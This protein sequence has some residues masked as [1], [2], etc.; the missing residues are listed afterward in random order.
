MREVAQQAGVAISSVSRVL[1]GHPDVSSAMRDK[2]M[3]VVEALGY[4]PDMLAQ[5]LRRQ[6][7]TS[8]GFAASNISNPVLTDAVRGAEGELRRAGFSL[9][10]T[11]ADGDP[12]LDAANIDLLQRRRVDA[13][14][15]AHGDE[16][17]ASVRTAIQEADVPLVLIDRDPPR[18]SDIPIVKFDHRKGMREAAEHLRDLGHKDIALLIGGPRRPARERKAGVLDVYREGSGL[19]CEVLE[20]DFSI[21]FGYAATR[22]ILTQA[23]RPTALIAGGN[24]IMHGSLRALR[25]L[26]VHL[27]RDLSFVGCDDV[28]VAEFHDP[29]IA[30]VRRVPWD[31]G[32]AAARMLVALL[33][34]EIEPDDVT[35]PTSFAPEASCAEPRR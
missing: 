7:T 16:R 14:L 32:V 13:I 34:E 19:G 23:T 3:A 26:G 12:E 22:E 1:S 21:E 2:V 4:H 11:D 25:E 31:A 30:V 35:L 8:V 5:G 10:L 15:L 28:A 17:H 20:G 29:Q 24:T 6:T 33:D 18:G 27:G 9:L